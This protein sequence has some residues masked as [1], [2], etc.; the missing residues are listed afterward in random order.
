VNSANGFVTP[1]KNAYAFGVAMNDPM[2]ARLP[3]RSRWPLAAAMQ[4]ARLPI[5]RPRATK[6]SS[7]LFG[8][9]HSSAACCWCP[10]CS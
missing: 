7:R 5:R 10:R 9:G 4:Q 2:S 6:K 3:T 1:I 8:H